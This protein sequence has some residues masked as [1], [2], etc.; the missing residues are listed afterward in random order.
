M[1]TKIKI[2]IGILAVGAV[3][4]SINHISCVS[5]SEQC[6]GK[7]DGTSC[8]TGVWCDLF[9]RTCGGQSCVGLGLGE[10]SQ[11]KCLSVKLKQLTQ[12]ELP[13]S[14]ILKGEWSEHPEKKNYVI[15][16]E[17]DWAGLL[18]KTGAELPEPTDFT[19]NMVIAAFQGEYPTGGYSIE[20]TKIVETENN[21][22]V[23]V[24]EISPGTNC[25]VTKAF[26]R[27]YHII[28]VQKSDKEVV[29]K[30][31]KLVRECKPR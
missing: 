22:E 27:P 20:I 29:F 23:F 15:K 24:K 11:G 1:S 7:P 2:L 28:K 25:N 21:I 19:K 12:E 18:S 5:S 13:F 26:T 4:I 16:T 6:K 9:G 8:S 17:G 31:E 30:V 3:I 14:T 10:C